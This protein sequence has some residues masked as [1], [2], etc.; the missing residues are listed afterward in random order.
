M[1]PPPMPSFPVGTVYMT[2]GKAPR[3]CTVTDIW[4]TYNAKGQ[5]VRVRY[6]A[7]HGLLGQTVTDHDV[8]E[9]TI[10]MGFVR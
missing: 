8:T 2:R 1:N 6:V 10:K 5:L 3:H 7:E 9:T 4:R